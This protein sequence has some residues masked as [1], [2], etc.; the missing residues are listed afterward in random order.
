MSMQSDLY[1]ITFEYKEQVTTSDPYHCKIPLCLTEHSSWLLNTTPQTDVCCPADADPHTCNRQLS[2]KKGQGLCYT[3]AAG[4]VP[5]GG[6]GR[7]LGA[8]EPLGFSSSARTVTRGLPCPASGIKA[9]GPWNPMP[10]I[11]P[12]FCM[13]PGKHISFYTQ[14]RTVSF[15]GEA[16]A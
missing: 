12:S 2:R 16:I 10:E 1:N 8:T 15:I 11:L 4:F 9:P 5:R 3:F 14:I 13:A 6:C 7:S